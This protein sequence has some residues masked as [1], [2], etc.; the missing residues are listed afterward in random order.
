MIQ[1]REI[2]RMKNAVSEPGYECRQIKSPER[3]RHCDEK[4]RTRKQTYTEAQYSMRSPPIH[5]ES[6]KRLAGA[7]CD[8]KYGHQ[9]ADRRIRNRIFLNE[10]WKQGRQHQM[11]KRRSAVSEPD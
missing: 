10:P 7:R 1:Q 6:R 5:Q 11:K 2:G 4:S 8:E 9:T 3:R